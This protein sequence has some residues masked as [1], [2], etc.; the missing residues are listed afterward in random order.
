M[1]IFSICGYNT[2]ITSKGGMF[3]R[4]ISRLLSRFCYNHPNFAIPRLMKYIV[5]GNVIVWILDLISRGLASAWLSFV[6]GYIFQGQVWRMATFVFVPANSDPLYF[7]LAML[8][9]YYLGS[10]LEQILGSTRFT[11]FYLLGTALTV[12]CG[13]AL[14]F[15][16]LRFWPVVDMG[17]INLSLF[18]AFATLY[19]DMQF[20]I[21]FI[22]PIRGKWLA[23]V[24]VVLIGLDIARFVAADLYLM[25]LTPIVSLLNWLLFFGENIF[26]GAKTVHVRVQRKVTQ[27]PVDLRT[28]Q[29][30]VQTQKGYLHKCVV[31]GVTDADDRTMEFRYCSKCEGYHCYCANHIN[32]HTH[33]Q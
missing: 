10:Q 31:C 28:A 7:A 24:Y 21:Y 32:N 23:L 17:Y 11:L 26:G 6:P 16:P 12:L 25:A 14:W 5:F 20:R 33:V 18:L 22:L 30:Q 29:K 13:L 1:D 27:K 3:M 9:Y 8:M 4:G 19:P 15:S 2:S